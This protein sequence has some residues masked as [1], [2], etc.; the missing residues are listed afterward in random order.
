LVVSIS[1]EGTAERWS[2]DCSNGLRRTGHREA[3]LSYDPRNTVARSLYAS[4]GF[5][6]TGELDDDET[7]AR[8]RLT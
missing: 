8:K 6:E 3:A 7:V 5:I 1:D 4:M 2:L